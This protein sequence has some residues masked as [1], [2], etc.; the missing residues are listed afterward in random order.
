MYDDREDDDTTTTHAA[1][2]DTLSAHQSASKQP[3]TKHR[4]HRRRIQQD[5][6]R[7]LKQRA[8]ED[9]ESLELEPGPKERVNRFD[10]G[11]TE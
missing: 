8:L 4:R 9:A 3:P 5:L 11:L 2:K 1:P 10:L 7:I 6:T